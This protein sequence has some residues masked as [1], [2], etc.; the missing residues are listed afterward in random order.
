MGAA[1]YYSSGEPGEINVLPG[2]DSYTVLHE[3]GHLLDYEAL[4]NP[5][6]D[7]STWGNGDYVTNYAGFMAAEDFAE[8]FVNW[9][10]YGNASSDEN[11][12]YFKG[13]GIRP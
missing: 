12:N 10:L 13:L 8:T 9:T 11:A 3:L 4:G 1:G 6:S 2:S 7:S 5:S